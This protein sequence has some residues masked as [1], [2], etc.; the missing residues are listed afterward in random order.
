MQHVVGVKVFN[1]LTG[2]NINLLVPIGIQWIQFCKLIL[3][4]GSQARKILG[5]DFR[6]VQSIQNSRFKIRNLGFKIKVRK[7]WIWNFELNMVAFV[8]HHLKHEF[9]CTV[10]LC[11]YSAKWCFQLNSNFLVREFIEI[12]QA[13]QFL[14]LRWK[15]INKHLY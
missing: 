6:V 15:L 7:F 12:T 1:I 8:L 14:I 2:N 4:L 9:T 3:L 13:Y 10:K 5:Y 11:F